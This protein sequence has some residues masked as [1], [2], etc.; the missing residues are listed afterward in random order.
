MKHRKTQKHIRLF[1]SFCA[2]S[3]LYICGCGEQLPNRAK[4]N[5]NPNMMAKLID[6]PTSALVTIIPS[7]NPGATTIDEAKITQ[8][9][10]QQFQLTSSTSPYREAQVVVVFHG[11]TLEYLVVL[12]LHKDSYDVKTTKLVIDQNYVVQKILHDYQIQEYDLA[13]TTSNLTFYAGCPNN[14]VQLVYAT[15]E[16]RLPSAVDGV[17]K[18]SQSA[19]Q[20]GYTVKTLVGQAAT[21]SSYKDWLSCPNLKGLGSVGHGSPSGIMLKGG[22]L[23]S[24]YFRSLSSDTGNGTVIYFNSCQTHNP[25]LETSIVNAGYQKFI[26]GNVNLMIGPSEKVFK[27]FWQKAFAKESM[28]KAVPACE[29]ETRYPRKGSHGISGKGADIFDQGGGSGT[30]PTPSDN[31]TP[32][33]DP[34]SNNDNDTPDVNP[35]SDNGNDTPSINPPDNTPDNTQPNTPEPDNSTPD[36][37]AGSAQEGWSCMHSACAEGLICVPLYRVGTQQIVAKYCLKP[38][39]QLGFDPTCSSREICRSTRASGNICSPF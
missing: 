2:L 16:Q 4:D 10:E 38:C 15:P 23:S 37:Q 27:C 35:P 13:E 29:Q 39:K 32:N 19:E 1:F 36:P 25:P 31:D 8:L 33:I 11:E 22:V 28:T 21:V 7:L 20:A 18:A 17:E 34:P 12:L 14:N 6:G 30:T 24:S 3:I 5:I 26:G 9:I